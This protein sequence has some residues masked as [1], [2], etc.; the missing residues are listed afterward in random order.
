MGLYFHCLF[1]FY[2]ELIFERY[3]QNWG[4][5]KDSFLFSRNF[6]SE[7][8]FRRTKVA[9]PI[10]G[11]PSP[12]FSTAWTG[13]YHTYVLIP[14][15]HQVY[16]HRDSFWKFCHGKGSQEFPCAFKASFL[17]FQIFPSMIWQ[18]TMKIF[19]IQSTFSSSLCISLSLVEFKL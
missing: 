18:C 9:P 12:S 19:P 1:L 3:F 10:W 2:K 11:W 7:R 17:L 8:P 6:C 5:Q 15:L 4:Q 16:P 13:Y 14:T